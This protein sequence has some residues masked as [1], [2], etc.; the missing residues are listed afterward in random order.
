MAIINIA[1]AT[2]E[3]IVGMGL[4]DHLLPGHKL[5]VRDN[6]NVIKIENFRVHGMYQPDAIAAFR[7]KGHKF[8]IMANEGDAREYTGY[9][10]AL[11]FS[12]S[13]YV[14]DPSFPITKP[15]ADLARL[16]VSTGSGD[17]DG[18]GDFDRID[19]FGARSVSI[20]NDKGDLIWDSGEMFERLSQAFHETLTRFNT[21]N[22][23]NDL[24]N[25][26]DDKDLGPEGLDV[27]P[28]RSEPEWKGLAH[29]VERGEQH[30]DDL[31]GGGCR[32]AKQRHPT[33]EA[34][35][36]VRTLR[37][38]ELDGHRH[39]HWRWNAVQQGGSILPLPDR[40]ERRLIEQRY[41]FHDPRIGHFALFV[42]R[43]FDDDVT[44]HAGGLG[45]G[46]INRGDLFDSD[47]RTD[48]TANADRSGQFRASSRCG[49]FFFGGLRCDTLAP[50]GC[51]GR[52]TVGCRFRRDRQFA[53]TVVGL[54]HL[55]ILRLQLGLERRLG[56]LR[57]L[58]RLRGVL[59]CSCA[60]GGC[61]RCA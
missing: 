13:A 20:R 37:A 32:H 57:F 40:V 48:L 12:N 34:E 16:N 19:I 46:R 31:A 35:F 30:D 42:N 14:L 18:D 21:T 7:Q 47:R 15:N 41:R 5:D 2:V 17:V 49:F 28:G 1:G 43:R 23:A 39:D 24:D 25:R 60:G 10:E 44:L 29:R 22:S 54:H 52:R 55:R 53:G 11:R 38:S 4:K 36:S 56:R 26:S 51:V 45:D 8:L 33:A 59:L 61:Q 50:A 3:K 27:R 6:D 9:L 58:Q